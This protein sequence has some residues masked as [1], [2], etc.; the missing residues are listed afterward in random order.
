MSERLQTKRPSESS[1]TQDGHVGAYVVRDVPTDVLG[2][3]R[4]EPGET[5]NDGGSTRNRSRTH[6]SEERLRVGDVDAVGS[7]GPSVPPRPN[8]TRRDRAK[9]ILKELATC[10]PG[11]ESAFVQS[12]VDLGADALPAIEQ[13]F[14]GT[15]WFDRRLPHQRPPRGR[16]AFPLGRVVFA[17]GDRAV[18]MLTSLL[19][20]TH[21]DQRYYAALMALDLGHPSLIAGLGKALFDLDTGIR[22]LVRQGLRDHQDKPAFTAIRS[23]VHRVMSDPGAEIWKRAFALETMGVFRDALAVSPIIDLLREGTPELLPPAGA[24]LRLLAAQ[25]FG[26]NHQKWANWFRKY[27]RRSRLVWLADSLTHPEET[28]RHI[29]SRE[30]ARETGEDFGDAAAAPKAERKRIQKHYRAWMK[31]RSA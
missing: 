7:A 25:D 22:E 23:D 17:L 20:A 27:G 28:V 15:L 2:P 3:E 30:L 24:V 10:G 12:L 6:I 1:V 18:P 21:A 5:K 14:P 31:K 13:T 26:T 11:D 19:T 4:E 9:K 29:A 16:D 8:P